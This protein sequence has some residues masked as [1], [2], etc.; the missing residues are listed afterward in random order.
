LTPDNVA[1]AVRRVR[2]FMVDVSSGIED[3]VPGFKN[4][5]KLRDFIQAA[6]GA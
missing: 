5:D 4:L 1:D 2:P 6:K 3:D